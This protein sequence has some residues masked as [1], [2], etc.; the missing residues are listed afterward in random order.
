[1]GHGPIKYNGPMPTKARRRKKVR[2]GVATRLRHAKK[3]N[4][5]RIHDDIAKR[6]WRAIEGKY[7]LRGIS[8]ATGFHHESVRRWFQGINVVALPFVEPLCRVTGVNIEWMVTGR[9][10]MVKKSAKG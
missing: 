8:E 10:P 4:L 3:I 1:M 7:T 5:D 9:G 6:L 2:S